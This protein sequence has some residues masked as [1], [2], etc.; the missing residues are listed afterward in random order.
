M[1][2]TTGIP[3]SNYPECNSNVFPM[4]SYRVIRSII[5]LAV[6]H[7]GFVHSSVFGTFDSE[8]ISD[9]RCTRVSISL[10]HGPM[11]LSETFLR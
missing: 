11:Y 2:D 7:A 9:G 4:E 8:T 10:L 5:M 3:F 6:Q 1:Y